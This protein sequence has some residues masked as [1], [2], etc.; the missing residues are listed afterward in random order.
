MDRVVVVG[1]SLAAVHAVEA[2]R[3]HGYPGEI[4]LVGAEE[5]LPYD[6]PPL[7][8]EALREGVEPAKLLLREPEWYDAHGVSLHLGR[9]AVALDAGDRHVVVDGGER[10]PYDGVLLATGSRPR[11]VSCGPAAGDRPVRSLR[12]L[13]DAVALREELLEARSLVVIGGGFIG[14]EVAATAREMGVEVTVVELAPAPLSRVLGDEVGH[15]FRHYHA[16][17]GIDV[18]CGVAVDE[19]EHS[20]GNSKVRLRDG[21][22]LSADLVVAGVGAQPATDWLAGSGLDLGDGVRC[23]ESLR[24][25]VPD[26][27]AAGDVANWYNPLFDESMRVEQWN[28]AVVQGRHAAGTLLGGRDS[29]AV[30]PYFW[31]DQFEAK[32]RF[33]GRSNAASDVRVVESSDRRLVAL[34]GRDDKIRGALCVNAPRQLALYRKAI[35]DQ[36]AWADID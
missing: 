17:H 27:V 15:W 24:T 12:S 30:V 14:L 32:M 16:A 2:L 33:V 22:V 10:L 9:P 31:S 7:S 1:A 3:E 35:E 36:V 5:S 4:A 13:A 26:V 34:F 29:C 23:D 21:T 18:R 6:R 25:T 28:N 20:P 8:K 19:I 11:T